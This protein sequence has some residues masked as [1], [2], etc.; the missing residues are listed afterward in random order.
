MV[1]PRQVGFHP[2]RDALHGGGA[3]EEHEGAA[4]GRAHLPQDALG[5]RLLV[6]RVRGLGH[7]AVDQQP[8]LPREVE[9]AAELGRARVVAAKASRHQREVAPPRGQRGARQRDGDGLGEEMLAQD[10][11][12]IHGCGG[13]RHARP[14]LALAGGPGLDPVDAPRNR[15]GEQRLRACREGVGTLGVGVELERVR[16]LHRVVLQQPKRAGQRLHGVAQA[17][18]HGVGR[19][20]AALAASLTRRSGELVQIHAKALE[21]VLARLDLSQRRVHTR[22]GAGTH[23]QVRQEAAASV[24]QQRA[25]QMPHGGLGELQAE[26][27]ARDILDLVR[28]VQDHML[29]VRQEAAAACAQRQVAEEQRVVAHQQVGVLHA[30]SRR[31]IEALLVGGTPTTHAVVRVALGLVPDRPRRLDRKRGQGTVARLHGPVLELVQRMTLLLVGEEPIL[32]LARQA[33]S[34]QAEVVAATLDQHRAELVGGH[35]AKQRDVLLEDLLLQT[36]RLRDHHHAL[37]T[38]HDA[39][40]RRD[41]VREALA[42]SRAGLHHQTT[43]ALERLLDQ[44][45]HLQ[46]LRTELEAGKTTRERT[47]VAQDGFG[48]QGHGPSLAVVRNASGTSTG[49]SRARFQRPFMRQ[50]RPEATPCSSDRSRIRRLPS[51]PT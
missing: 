30:P 10:R 5:Q 45:R 37:A 35:G 19:G 7:A 51:T 41:Q 48:V 42:H 36:D 43:L 8:D 47:G 13:E 4:V 16:L 17:V 15:L 44:L 6:E 49:F 11:G 32:P 33:Q 40:D 12:H 31:L 21:R 24:G 3:R 18:R 26:V 39:P 9:R 20:D 23:T 28:L 38:L 2:T 46:L 14:T 29:V 34:T 22:L 50:C 1:V 27:L 25:Q